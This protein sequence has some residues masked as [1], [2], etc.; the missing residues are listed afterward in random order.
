MEVGEKIMVLLK[1]VWIS[2]NI[3]DKLSPI[4]QILGAKIHKKCYHVD[5]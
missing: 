5:I 2:T 1:T 3:V 4:A